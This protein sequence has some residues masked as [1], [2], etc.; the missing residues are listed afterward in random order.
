M[1]RLAEQTRFPAAMAAMA[2]M[3]AAGIVA[4]LSAGEENLRGEYGSNG[5]ASGQLHDGLR[6][7]VSE[8]ID[9][10]EHAAANQEPGE[11]V[12]RG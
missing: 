6:D 11:E 2:A 8:I 7:D 9:A 10:Q 3:A 4:V 12:H 1:R 5:R